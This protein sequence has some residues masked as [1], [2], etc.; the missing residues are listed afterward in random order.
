MI[1]SEPKAQDF[2]EKI[3]YKYDI[4]GKLMNRYDIS[5]E[6]SRTY[7]YADGTKFTIEDEAWLYISERG[8]HRV[9]T[10]SG[11]VFYPRA[12]WIALSW[13][14]KNNDDPVQF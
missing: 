3:M 13:I 5:S 11:E 2:K 7:H 14:P 6:Q 1:I 8:S 4:K 12:D 10:V 9:Q